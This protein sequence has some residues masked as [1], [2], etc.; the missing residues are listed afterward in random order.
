MPNLTPLLSFWIRLDRRVDRSV[1]LRH[2]LVLAVLKYL[3]DVVLVAAATGRFWT[4]IDYL[5]S[6]PL[7]LSTTFAGAPS[8]LMPV[9]AVWAIPFLWIGISL[10]LRRTL[11]SG[12]SAWTALWF[13]VPYANYILIALLCSMPSAP[14]EPVA[15]PEVQPRDRRL[16][17]ALLAMAAGMMLGL[18]MMA[19]SIVA[20]EA[21]GLALFFGTPFVIGT[22]VGYM[23]NRR[24]P[25][26]E[27]HTREVVTMT[28]ALLGGA[29]FLLGSEGVVCLL[30]AFPLSLGLAILGAN[31]GRWIAFGGRSTGPEA[32]FGILMLPIMA[33][34]EPDPAMVAPREV[35]SAIEIDATPAE[36]W[37]NVVA[38][39]PL[40]EPA[41]LLF[42][43]GIAYPREA[44]IE[45]T[46][47]GAVRYCVF[48]T[49]AFVEPIT[50]WEPGVRLSFDVS[51]SPAP[52]RE[53]T[54]WKNLQPPHL[55]GFLV[56]VRGEFRLVALPDGR[57]RLEGS[58]WYDL[59]MQ[60]FAYWSFFSD[61]IIGTIHDRVLQHIA[62]VS[63]A[64]A[65]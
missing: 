57:T 18:G 22:L 13:F 60:P 54:I 37:E 35:R 59:R 17:S 51:D 12:W 34:L 56:P 55:D 28:L 44:Y 48:S 65:G 33:L 21:Y 15:H 43:A 29:A 11:D 7:L 8:W 42:R 16:P 40:P 49:G 31:I 20:F 47:V 41:E 46:G 63:E 19:L 50:H 58:T 45:G 1:Y 5:R 25:T 27:R 61:R 52:M 10:T 38:F 2:G 6:V 36:V 32:A 64:E 4:P 14:V 53:L 39:P 23:F 30:M 62:K 24:Y 3:G 26:S 9:L